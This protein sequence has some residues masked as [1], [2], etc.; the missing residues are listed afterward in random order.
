MLSSNSKN[1]YQDRFWYTKI[2]MSSLE[3]TGIKAVNFFQYAGS[4]VSPYQNQP[5]GRK[6]SL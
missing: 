5:R 2:N 1:A 4:R 3:K 6:G